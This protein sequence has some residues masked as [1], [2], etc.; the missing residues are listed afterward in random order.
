MRLD[1]VGDELH[2]VDSIWGRTRNRAKPAELNLYSRL[3]LVGDELDQVD[4]I[5]GRTRWGR[6]RNGVKPAATLGRHLPLRATV[7]RERSSRKTVSYEDQI[8]SKDKYPSIF[9]PQME[10]IVFIIFQIVFATHAVL[11]IGEYI[12]IIHQIFL[13][14]RDW[15]KR[16]TWV[17]IPQLKLGNIRGYSPIFKTARVA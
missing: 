4:S 3:D 8:L 12:I 16:I 14:A 13:F 17:N 7:F 6:T 1:L 15:S 9:L 10:A 5:W 11:K 2:Q